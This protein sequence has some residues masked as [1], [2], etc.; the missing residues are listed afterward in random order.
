[1]QLFCAFPIFVW[2]LPSYL[3]FRAACRDKACFEF[4]NFLLKHS[5]W[6]VC[7]KK[8]E[9]FSFDKTFFINA[10]W[11]SCWSVCTE[12][13]QYKASYM[14]DSFFLEWFFLCRGSER[15]YCVIRDYVLL[16]FVKGENTKLKSANCEWF[17]G[18]DTWTVKFFMRYSWFSTNF[19]R[20]NRVLAE[21][22]FYSE[23]R[24]PSHERF[25][26]SEMTY[27]RPVI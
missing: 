17:A 4:S 15:G 5:F 24:G 8:P 19:L 16:I 20:E 3:L 2:E 10:R 11:V 9:S 14:E 21:N 23:A 1:M 12:M 18:R 22:K 6:R 7:S 25:W 27:L 13:F 26:R